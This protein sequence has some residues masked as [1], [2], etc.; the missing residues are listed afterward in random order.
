MSY[1]SAREQ[2]GYLAR[3]SRV[4][5]AVDSIFFFCLSVGLGNEKLL[6]IAGRISASYI[7]QSS[8]Y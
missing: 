6:Y 5:C 8:A 3:A 2:S 1:K 4:A 7:S